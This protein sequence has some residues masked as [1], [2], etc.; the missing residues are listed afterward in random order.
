MPAR[1]KAQVTTC[2][3]VSMVA[4]HTRLLLFKHYDLLTISQTLP[5]L[6]HARHKTI[7]LFIELKPPRIVKVL[8]LIK[9][10]IKQSDA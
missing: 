4:S 2:Q 9:V 7:I 1:N 8:T 5:W 10:L 6:I 3:V